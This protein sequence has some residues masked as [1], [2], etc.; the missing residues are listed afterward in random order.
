MIV[1]F[2][3]KLVSILIFIK[4]DIFILDASPRNRNKYSESI[5][6]PSYTNANGEI[7]PQKR[8]NNGEIYSY[9]TRRHGNRAAWVFL[10]KSK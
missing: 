6:F 9:L 7:F 3:I 2:R 8:I 4:R 10:A 5:K 1:T